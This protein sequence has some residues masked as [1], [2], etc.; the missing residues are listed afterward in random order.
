[1]FLVTEQNYKSKFTWVI[2]VNFEC[3]NLT[4]TKNGIDFHF[5]GAEIFPMTKNFLKPYVQKPLDT[6]E[7]KVFN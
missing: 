5:L 4:A 7:K 2:L 6:I 1:M 3:E